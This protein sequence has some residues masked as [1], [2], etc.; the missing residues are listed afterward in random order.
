MTEEQ[1][2]SKKVSTQELLRQTDKEKHDR[3]LFIT[4]AGLIVNISL[5]IV[6]L[7][8]GVYGKSQALVAD[9][10]HTGS[11]IATDIAVLVGLRYWSAPPDKSHPH[12]HA[13]IE[14]FVTTLIGLALAAVGIGIVMQ[15][16]TTIREAHSEPPSWIT[17]WIAL[18]SVVTK[19]C[20]YHW[21]ARIGRKIKSPALVANAWHHRSDSFSSIPVVIAIAATQIWPSLSFLDHV[22]A[23]IVSV[24]LFQAAWTISWPSIKQLIDTGAPEHIF[25]EIYRIAIETKGVKRVHAV[26]SRFVGSDLQIDLHVM[27]EGGI[28]VREGH[29]IS[30]HV[31]ERLI[32]GI[33]EVIDVVVHT[34][35]FD[36]IS[37]PI[38]VL[39]ICQKNSCRSQ[40]AEGFAR[41]LKPDE[42][43]P[44]SAGSNPGELD[45]RAVKVMAEAGVD[46]SQQ[47]PKH[48]NDIKHVPFDA[49]VT[50]CNH[51]HET[52]PVFPAPVKIVH[53]GFE[54]P[55]AL[56]KKASSE[57]EALK[58]Y[59]KVRDEIRRFI[60]T[61]P[62]SLELPNNATHES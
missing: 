17:F 21:T 12:G 23:I 46:I 3:A 20:M 13:R 57:E 30:E 55:P 60:E 38:R 52:C 25:D 41:Y 36:L 44:Y 7:I 40:M 16:V 39:F 48:I 2:I 53:V 22:G 19:E 8:G 50:V 4:V 58:Q 61:L 6:K 15:A 10:A 11:D 1:T 54:D 62:E 59:R 31:K 45:Q 51:A 47:K 37:R 32:D 26:R 18:A 5:G 27:V 33:P 28:T 56:A 35:P 34:E 24:F 9:A 49:V 29:D 14:T 43:E 42:L